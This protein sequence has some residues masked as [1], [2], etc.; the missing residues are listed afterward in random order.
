MDAMEEMEKMDCRVLEENVVLKG[1]QA[2]KA[3][4]ALL[5]L[6]DAKDYEENVV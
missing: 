3:P 1:L 6:L 2:S 5:G 4:L